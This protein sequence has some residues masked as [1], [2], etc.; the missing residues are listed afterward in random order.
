MKIGIREAKNNLS[1]YGQR[2]HDGERIV[3]SKNGTPWFEMVPCTSSPR[4]VSPLPNAEP[5]VNAQEA[6]A[7][8]DE[9]DLAG[10][11]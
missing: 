7:P 4:N 5:L 8:L 3:V 1:A 2:A 11:Q 6:V 10:W 9:T